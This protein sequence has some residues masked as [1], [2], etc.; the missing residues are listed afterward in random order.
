M[1]IPLPMI[2]YDFAL[3]YKSTSGTI[4]PVSTGDI[5]T[6][7]RSTITLDWL[8]ENQIGIN[9]TIQTPFGD[10]V[11]TYADFTASGRPLKAVEDFI[12]AEALPRY[13]NTHTETADFGRYMTQLREGARDAIRQS[14]N[15]PET[16]EV[17][18]TG[19]GSTAAIHKLISFVG[20]T[21]TGSRDCGFVEPAS[22]EC[23]SPRA[24]IF[25]GPQEHHSNDLPWRHSEAAIE[26]IP[27]DAAGKICQDSLKKAL[28][29]YQDTT[30]KIGAFSAAS[31]VTG[32]VAD[33]TAIT[34]LLHEHDCLAV[35]DYAAGG[36]YLPIDVAGQESSEQLDAVFISPHKFL[37]GPGTPGVLV[38]RK[39]LIPAAPSSPGGGT[40][41]FVTSTSHE[42]L[43]SEVEREEPGT[44]DC[45]GSIRAGLAFGI[46]DRV[47]TA[48][49]EAAEHRWWSY[50][51]ERWENHPAIEILGDL[52]AK[53]LPIV[54][55]SV[56]APD[57]RLLHHNLVA[58]LLNDLF[59][60]QARSGCSCAGPY[61]LSLLGIDDAQ[62]AEYLSLMNSGYGSIKPGWTRVGFHYSMTRED[63]EYVC[64]AVELIAAEGWRLL[65]TYRIGLSTGVW[66]HSS[67][68]RMDPAP[69]DLNVNADM[70]MMGSILG[71]SDQEQPT[72]QTQPAVQPNTPLDVVRREY[73]TFARDYMLQRTPHLVKKTVAE[74]SPEFETA[75]WFALSLESVDATSAA[76]DTA[77]CSS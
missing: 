23:E 65:D 57:G 45:I 21:S 53:R 41:S 72:V 62:A 40:V 6:M 61:G 33:V 43:G 19:A 27:L 17:I 25:V 38:V 18:F 30:L 55:F 68:G 1:I 69:T 20:L 67:L 35:W 63:V 54:S 44:P 8:R 46:K 5:K 52:D 77:R 70:S 22:S 36:P 16:H 39:D 2:G 50:C 75:R 66:S 47:T 10:R 26:R 12:R 14:V 28:Q 31:N 4:L 64:D 56:K 48:A 51:L 76:G 29:R 32:I 3:R 15:A 13:A 58:T 37:G 34:S 42:F 9:T 71:V 60:I 74:V 24:V 73:L 7:N 11:S 49:I 59:G